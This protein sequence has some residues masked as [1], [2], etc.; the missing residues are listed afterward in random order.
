M[1]R[2][3]RGPHVFSAAGLPTGMCLVF[4]ILSERSERR[5]PPWLLPFARSQGEMLRYAQHDNPLGVR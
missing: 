3:R 1:I 2:R 5:I 4:V